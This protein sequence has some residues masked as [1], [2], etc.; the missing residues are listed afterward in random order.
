MNGT[1]I[2]E[3]FSVDEADRR[4]DPVGRFVMQY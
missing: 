4:E 1:V 2:S 3:V